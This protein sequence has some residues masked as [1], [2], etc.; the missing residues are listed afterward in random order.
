MTREAALWAACALLPAAAIIFWLLRRRPRLPRAWLLLSL[1]ASIVLGALAVGAER[2]LLRLSEGDSEIFEAAQ[3]PLMVGLMFV[4]PL[5]E[6]LKLSIAWPS[7]R[8]RHL[9]GPLEGVT[10]GALSGAGFGLART[11]VTLFFAPVGWPLAASSH[12]LTMLMQLF[13]PTTWGLMLGYSYPR[14]SPRRGFLATW[15][16]AAV[17]HGVFE[18]LLSRRT[19]FGV[20][21]TLPLLVTMGLLAFAS[22]QELG[23]RTGRRKLSA[24]MAEPINEIGAE[25]SGAGPR[26]RLWPVLHGVLVNQGALVAMIALG[27]YVGRRSGV[28]FTRVNETDASSIAPVVLLGAFAMLS[29][30]LGGFLQARSS[31]HPTIIEPALSA[32]LSIAAT[33]VLFGSTAPLGFAVLLASAPV[34]LLLACA[35]AWVGMGR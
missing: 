15:L 7:F 29:F 33:T 18:H 11:F 27:A 35:G 19:T 24:A 12:L 30:P 1:V 16:G 4:G 5:E 10:I 17:A 23:S 13:L 21:A 8:A 2:L 25:L 9:R 14:L 26:I 22:R 3:T 20:L 28:D 31:E 32:L 6:A 34:A